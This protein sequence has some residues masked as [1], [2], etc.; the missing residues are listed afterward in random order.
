[1]ALY[2]VQVYQLVGDYWCM[3]GFLLLIT[4]LAVWVPLGD[5]AHSSAVIAPDT[6][7]VHLLTLLS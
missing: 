2:C 7:P 6:D 4:S 3:A 5:F 1:M